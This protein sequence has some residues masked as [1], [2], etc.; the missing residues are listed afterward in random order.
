MEYFLALDD[1]KELIRRPKFQVQRSSGFIPKNT[2]TIVVLICLQSHNEPI[3]S[4][5]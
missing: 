1:L 2:K 4:E 5:Q 3:I